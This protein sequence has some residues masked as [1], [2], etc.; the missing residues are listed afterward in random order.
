M[1]G[2]KIKYF[3]SDNEVELDSMAF[4]KFLNECGIQRRLSCS[5]TPQQNGVA[6]RLNR[7]LNDMA[8]CFLLESN[9]PQKYWTEA[10]NTAVHVRNRCPS[11]AID[12]DIPYRRWTGKILNVSYFHKFGCKT[13][14]LYKSSG[15][16]KFKPRAKEAIFVGYPEFSKGYKLWMVE[17]RKF[18]ISRDVNFRENSTVGITSESETLQDGSS[19][20]V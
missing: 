10:I 13:F 6:E 1:T 17:E 14:V 12:F 5:W 15:G 20:T 3:Q 4:N 19:R 9:L 8:R 16:N 18:T 7:T 11:N 2:N